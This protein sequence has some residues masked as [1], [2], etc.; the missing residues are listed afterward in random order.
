[1]SRRSVLVAGLLA[2]ALGRFPEAKEID[3]EI[4][5]N[6]SQPS[7]KGPAEWFTGPVRI[8]PLFQVP[9]PGRVGDL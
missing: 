5:R 2:G 9:E 8:D 6:G 3:V 4:E 1:M 7:R